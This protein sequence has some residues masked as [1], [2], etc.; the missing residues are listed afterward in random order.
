MWYE[1]HSLSRYNK[2][3]EKE[4]V[5]GGV[6]EVIC[7]DEMTIMVPTFTHFIQYAINHSTGAAVLGRANALH[8]ALMTFT[9]DGWMDG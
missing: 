5:A 6:K 2:G 3:E 8:C 1:F 4:I 7:C 9:M